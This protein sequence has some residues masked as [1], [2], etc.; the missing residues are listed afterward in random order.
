MARGSRYGWLGARVVTPLMKLLMEALGG[1]AEL[2]PDKFGEAGLPGD[3]NM[4]LDT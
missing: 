2:E 3:E 1:D 4:A